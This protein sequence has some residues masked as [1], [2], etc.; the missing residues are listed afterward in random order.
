MGIGSRIANAVVTLEA[1]GGGEE[2]DGEDE[3]GGGAASPNRHGRLARV[4]S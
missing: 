1:G 3:E 2:D 4:G